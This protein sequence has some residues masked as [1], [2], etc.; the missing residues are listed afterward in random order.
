MASSKLA[1]LS[2]LASAAAALG[3]AAAL[4]AQVVRYVDDDAPP[5]GNGTSWNAAF[6]DLQDA[7]A[8]TENSPD[9][10]EIR[11]AQG[12]YTPDSGT[13]MG[14]YSFFVIAPAIHSGVTLWLKGGFAGRGAINPDLRD[15]ET[16]VTVLSGDLNGDDQPGFV[17]RTDNSYHV[18]TVNGLIFGWPALSGLT[19]RGGSTMGQVSPAAAG[20][21]VKI[22]GLVNGVGGGPVIEDC[23]ITDNVTAGNGG[24][25]AQI[26]GGRPELRRCLIENNMAIVRG[27]GVYLYDTWTASLD[28][29]TVRA[30]TAGSGGGIDGSVGRMLDVTSCVVSE[31]VA[32]EGGAGGMWIGGGLRMVNS[33]VS[34]NAASGTGGG[35]VVIDTGQKPSSITNSVLSRNTASRGAALSLRHFGAPQGFYVTNT[36]IWDNTSPLSPPVIVTGEGS[37][38][39]VSYSDVEGGVSGV[40]AYE[41]AAIEWGPGNMNLDPRFSNPAAGDFSLQ[42]FSPCIDT[43]NDWVAAGYTDIL[44]NPRRRDDPWMPNSPHGWVIDIGAYESQG[45]S[46]FADCNGNGSLDI[47][48]FGCFQTKFAVGNPAVD[49]NLDG[50]LNLADF[51]CFTTRF[52]VGCP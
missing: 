16:F 1:A 11:V 9:P 20:A 26:Q 3:T 12:T 37:T 36:L 44:G 42:G 2:R 10:I 6:R 7:L 52:A 40:G 14:V 49:C 32:S 21:G 28:S 25:I 30:N 41:G 31:N 27:G 39:A 46:C 23:I 45:P 8:N 4:H 18:V 48:D 33:V 17:N 22:H 47:A 51:G 5:G 38:A 43:G 19:V 29:C 24:G 34:G 50:V 15:P 35:I 13:G